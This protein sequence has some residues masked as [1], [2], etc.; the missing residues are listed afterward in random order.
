VWRKLTGIGLRRR[1]PN[2][3]WIDTR[4]RRD[5]KH[6]RERSSKRINGCVEQ[7]GRGLAGTNGQF[8]EN[9][10]RCWTD[11]DYVVRHDVSTGRR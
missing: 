2:V 4:D 9:C 7:L 8:Q 5:G 1:F 11:L 10:L 6:N 3:C